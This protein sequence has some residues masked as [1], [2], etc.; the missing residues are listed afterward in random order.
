MDYQIVTL[1]EK[2]MVGLSLRTKNHDKVVED[3]GALWQSFYGQ[4]FHMRPLGQVDK[5]AIG[6]YT[7]YEG[8]YTKPYT[9]VAGFE[10]DS[11]SDDI[12]GSQSDSQNQ[13]GL[14][15]VT[16]SGGTYAKFTVKGD[17]AKDVGAAWMAIW[18]M[19]LDRKYDCDFE[20][21]HNDSEDM[22]NQTVDIYISLNE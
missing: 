6:L 16:I 2:K 19:D 20:H 14:G 7:A 10:V 17:I 22:T 9:F 18:K 4:G 3:I 5:K 21:Y 13:E 12:V 1:E 11:S 8:D 15:Q